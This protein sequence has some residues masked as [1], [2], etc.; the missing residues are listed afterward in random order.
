M[1]S[2]VVIR[3]FVFVCFFD[4]FHGQADRCFCPPPV[5]LSSAVRTSRGKNNAAKKK[6]CHAPSTRNKHTQLTRRGR[7]RRCGLPRR[8]CHPSRRPFTTSSPMYAPARLT[9]HCERC[10]LRSRRATETRVA[11]HLC[12]R[13]AASS[14]T[15]ASTAASAQRCIRPFALQIASTVTSMVS[16]CTQPPS[17]CSLCPFPPLRLLSSP[18]A[19]F[20]ANVSWSHCRVHTP[21]NG[22]QTQTHVRDKKK[23]IHSKQAYTSSR[24]GV[25]TH[26]AFEW[27][28]LLICRHYMHASKKP[29]THDRNLLFGCLFVLSAYGTDGRRRAFHATGDVFD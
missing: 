14:Q 17:L 18:T 19:T 26:S 5:F 22:L 11:V 21:P 9:T 8:S 15:T 25:G 4:W 23:Q 13:D 1:L 2:T 7:R 16:H 27:Q 29:A 12:G 24:E 3:C 20:K 6:K 10:A 28:V